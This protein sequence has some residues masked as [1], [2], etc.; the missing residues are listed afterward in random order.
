MLPQRAAS[1]R[2]LLLLALAT[3]FALAAPACSKV[4]PSP[5]PSR[6]ATAPALD[7][8]A[9]GGPSARY[10]LEPGWRWTYE[11]TFT[12]IREE[13]EVE[14]IR[15]TAEV[16]TIGE[17]DLGELTAWGIAS[18]TLTT[19]PSG[20]EEWYDEAYYRRE[21]NAL[22]ELG[23]LLAGGGAL[24]TP[25]PMGGD[26]A[27]A[28]RIGP[29]AFATLGEIP[30]ALDRIVG[31]W[32]PASSVTSGEIYLRPEPRL[33]LLYPLRPGSNWVSLE[34][35]FLQ[36]REVVGRRAARTRAGTF[37]AAEVW[38]WIPS[39]EAG[40]TDW[41]ARIGLVARHIEIE[42]S[43]GTVFDPEPVHII[44]H[45]ELVSYERPRRGTRSDT[46]LEF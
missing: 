7:A 18:R 17:V 3:G 14:V 28:Y 12:V 43:G 23:S 20:P 44:D 6:V 21:G 8:Q 4:D 35:P 46:S 33:A 16:W 40:Y 2:P 19:G 5:T 26:S 15:S 10:P 24:V 32:T 31:G 45:T 42:A 11:R 9:A 29:Y 30:R 34:D 27:P 25:A 13:G 41:I 36:T 1:L 37:G 38:S 39:A 22:L